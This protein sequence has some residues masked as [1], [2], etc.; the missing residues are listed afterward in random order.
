MAKILTILDPDLRKIASTNRVFQNWA[1][2]FSCTPELYFEPTSEEQIVKI[3]ELAQRT[4][5]LVKA[6]GAGH[7]PSDLACTN[8]FMVKLDRLNQL[9]AVDIRAHTATVQAG[10]T[11]HELHRVLA[12]NGL[13]LS[14]LGSVS[15][16]TVA[17]VMATATH[18][19]GAN[20]KSLSTMVG[21]ILHC[22]PTQNPDIFRAAQCSL[23]ALGIITRM[24]LQCEPSFRLE[25]IQE[26]VP[27]ATTLST[28]S[29]IIHSAEHV[30]LWWFPHTDMTVVWRANRSIKPVQPPPQ[31]WLRDRL[32]GYHAYQA[33]LDVTRFEPMTQAL[34][35]LARF[36]FGV[37]FDRKMRLVDESYK[38]FNYDCMFPQYVNEWAIPWEQTSEALRKLDAFV[39]E[40]DMKVHWPVEVR[41]ADEDDKA[42]PDDKFTPSSLLFIWIPRP[43]G[44]P[45]PYK[46]YWQGYEE[47]MRSLGGRPHWA[48][49]HGQSCAELAA[50]YPHFQDFL[51]VRQEVDPAGIFLN[52]YLRRHIV[53]AGGRAVEP[54]HGMSHHEERR[55]AEAKEEAELKTEGGFGDP[56][57]GQI[58]ARL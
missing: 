14:N 55:V 7:S 24:T 9:L 39:K 53:G 3:L 30:R 28:M 26:P 42:F 44:R 2:T 18:G 40:N 51:R 19:T 48:K 21:L 46:K 15:D 5:K 49:A 20:F 33:A 12:E 17:G 34:P 10:M 16:Q 43:Y 29:A 57:D 11:L 27:L 37:L 50:S 36:F 47:I 8:G 25:A 23:G 52:D 54:E 38:V 31:S 32:L 45:V 58:L 1:K 4:G 13:A 22:T 56:G 6:V 35:S 41:F